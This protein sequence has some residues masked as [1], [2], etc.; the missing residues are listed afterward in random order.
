M[1]LASFGHVVSMSDR[2]G[3]FEHAAHAEPRREHGYC[4]DDMARL[5]IVAVREPDRSQVVR[6]LSRTA[7][8][9]LASSQRDRKSVV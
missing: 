9:F 8:R 4:T 2:F 3:M 6:E 7:L 1:T 5:L